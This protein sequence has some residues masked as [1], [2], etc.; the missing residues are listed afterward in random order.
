MKRFFAIIV[1]VLSVITAMSQSSG[2]ILSYN[3]GEQ[4]K[5]Y[6]TDQINQAVNDAE[7]NDTIYFGPGEYDL[8]SLPEYQSYSNRCINKPLV[9]IGSGAHDGGTRF[10]S[11]YADRIFLTV[12]AMMDESK[13]IFSFEGINLDGSSVIPHSNIKQLRFSNT[14]INYFYDRVDRE[15]LEDHPYID[16]LII[17]RSTLSYLRL[18]SCLTKHVSVYNSKITQRAYGGCDASFGVAAFDHCYINYLNKNFIGL[19]QHSIICDASDAGSKTSFENCQY[20]RNCENV[21]KNECTQITDG[22]DSDIQNLDNDPSSLGMCNDGT[23]YGTLGGKAPFSL[24]PSYPTADTSIDPDTNK[25]KSSID[26]DELNKKLT[27]TVKR[28]GE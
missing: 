4:L 2:I 20:R 23:F 9:F 13:R 10:N 25:A 12:D 5:Y 14:K 27:I 11:N 16:E 15:E 24:Y 17:D 1:A 21:M 7:V 28:L 26:Y 19:V 8:R 18:D 3:K 22:Y 6:N